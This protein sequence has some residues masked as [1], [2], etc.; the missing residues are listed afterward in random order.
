MSGRF[1]R[2]AEDK[3]PRVGIRLL[4]VKRKRTV[5]GQTGGNISI[6]GH[7]ANGP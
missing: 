4:A 7:A 1:K 2:R 5:K 3:Y 6:S